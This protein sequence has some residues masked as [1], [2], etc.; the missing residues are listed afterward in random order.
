MN[1][2]IKEYMKRLNPYRPDYAAIIFELCCWVCLIAIVYGVA[3]IW[4]M[5]KGI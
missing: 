2:R 5:E 4:W 1:N 3:M